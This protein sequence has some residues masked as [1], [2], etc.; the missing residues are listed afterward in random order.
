[1]CGKFYRLR[2]RG[3]INPPP[4]SEM[5]I[6]ALDQA[7]RR[8]GYAVYENDKLTQYGLLEAAGKNADEHMVDMFWKVYHLVEE[9]RPDC[10]GIEGVQFQSNYKTFALL[11][12]MQGVIMGICY[13][14]D[15]GLYIT[16]AS[17]WRAHCGVRSRT[18][19]EQKAEAIRSVRAM[20]IDAPEDTC[21]AILHG[22]Y[23]APKI[24][25]VS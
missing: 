1:M 5:K 15:I 20:G 22:R 8:T 9:V 14:K 18:R 13:L 6:L 17:E 3:G 23:L 19:K 25:N 21:E 24:T 10:L 7:T 2:M 11:A 12:R 4:F 16:S